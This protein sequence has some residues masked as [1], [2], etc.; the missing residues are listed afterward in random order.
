M[1]VNSNRTLAD[2]LQAEAQAQECQIFG[3]GEAFFFS[4][5]AVHTGCQA[6][7]LEHSLS[8]CGTWTLFA[9]CWLTCPTACGILGP[10]PGIRSALE[11]RFF[12]SGPLGKC[13]LFLN[14]AA[15]FNVGNELKRKM[16]SSQL[17]PS[18]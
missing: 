18:F 3:G 4:L 8:N 5:V 6:G 2:C 1:V 11:G 10:G 14:T 17:K 13:Q 7:A 16:H 15:S 9:T 12:T